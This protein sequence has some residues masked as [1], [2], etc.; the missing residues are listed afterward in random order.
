MQV[1]ERRRRLW[2]SSVTP[3]TRLGMLWVI[4][5]VAT[6]LG[7]AAGYAGGY[8]KAPTYTSE[9][10]LS[11]DPSGQRYTD[12]TAYVPDA[13]SL[14]QQ[15]QNL[16]LKVESDGVIDPAAK[17][18]GMTSTALRASL[19]VAVASGATVLNI[20]ADSESATTA[21]A[22]AAAVADSFSAS[23]SSNVKAQYTAQADALQ[24]SIDDLTNRINGLR[25]TDPLASSLSGQLATVVAQQ[26]LLRA[27]AKSPTTP[28]SVLQQPVVP[29]K[30]S[31]LPP[32]TLA[33][34]GAA[35]GFLIGLA[36]VALLRFRATS[37][38]R[39]P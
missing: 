36:I 23:V 30:S 38:A 35:L 33:I 31:S 6:A 2:T 19:T 25:P 39:R 27:R 15:L 17:K 20:D 18:L 10:Q 8:L 12:A 28:L 11:W 9:V 13:V 32:L 3:P 34:L 7:G 1:V 26:D 29:P 5:I 21:Q 16:I 14:A 22:I 37:A 4:V 24:A